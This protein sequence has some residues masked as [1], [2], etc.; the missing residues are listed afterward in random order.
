MLYV[1]TENLWDVINKHKVENWGQLILRAGK[2]TDYVLSTVML[3]K[4]Q[5][6]FK[7]MAL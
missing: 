2:I 6:N 1:N 7:L 4:A 3:P 5:L